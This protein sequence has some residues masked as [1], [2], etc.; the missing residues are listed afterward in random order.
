MDELETVFDYEKKP[1]AKSNDEL[2]FHKDRL[3]F[4]SNDDRVGI[5]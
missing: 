5:S 3:V 2:I 1:L 4:N